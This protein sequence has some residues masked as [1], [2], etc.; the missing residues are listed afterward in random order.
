MRI[1][2][3]SICFTFERLDSAN[4]GNALL[5]LSSHQNQGQCLEK[6]GGKGTNIVERSFG[7]ELLTELH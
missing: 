5:Y 7:V 6:R 3:S 4:C 1:D 2:A